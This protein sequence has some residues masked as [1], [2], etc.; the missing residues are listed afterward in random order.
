VTPPTSNRTGIQIIPNP[1]T[2]EMSKFNVTEERD[3]DRDG[4]GLLAPED[5][6]TEDGVFSW[7]SL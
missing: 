3:L 5:Q 2:L 7:I 4:G 6:A 1:E